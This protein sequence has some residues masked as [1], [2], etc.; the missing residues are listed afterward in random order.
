MTTESQNR[1]FKESWRDEYL[2]WICG[3]ANAQG[4]TLY[5]GIQDNSDICGVSEAKK[6]MEDIPNKVRDMLGILADVNLKEKDGKEYLEIITEAYPYPISFR[7][8]YY[9]RS[10][11]TNQELKG[12][13]L[14][15]FM[16]RKQGRTWDG[17]PVPFLK[18]EDLDNA[19]FE[20]FRKYAKRSGRMEE[21]DLQDN[22]H[23][24]LDKLRLI[25][26]TYLKRAAALL[27]HPDPERFVTGAFI[28]IGYFKEGANLIF[29]DEVHGNLFQQVKTTLDLLT[30]KYLRA[31]ISYEGIQRIESLPIPQEGLREALLNSVVHKAYESLAPIQIA[32]YDDKLE[33]WDCGVLPEDWTIDNLLGSHRSRPY[34][35]DIANVFFRA[36]EIEA[37][38]RGIERIIEACK[39]T[40]VPAPEFKYDGGGLWTVFHFSESYQRSISGDTQKTLSNTIQNSIQ[41]TIQKLTAQQQA[42]VTYLREHPTATRKELSENLPDATMGGIIHNLTRLQELG[43]LKRRGGRKQGYWEIQS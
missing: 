39:D 27:F 2:K 18:V 16:L 3:F 22:N 9:R 6:L 21:I 33:I 32:V 35:P 1:E 31:L 40:D 43:I 30:T 37:W 23:A 20:L 14:D 38:G 25:E 5:I 13:A 15:R 10:G 42:I 8:K 7:G 4:G 26:G 41:K 11:A 29:Q 24:L 34:N 28:K 17:V 19:T 12:A 36:G